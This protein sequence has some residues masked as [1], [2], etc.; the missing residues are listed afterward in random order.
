MHRFHFRA[1]PEPPSGRRYDPPMGRG[2]W[3]TWILVLCGLWLAACGD[4]DQGLPS[5]CTRGPDAV[6]RALQRAPAAVRIGGAP[7][8]RCVAE[9]SDAGELQA[10]GTSLVGAAAH[11]AAAARRDPGGAAELRLGYLIGAARRGAKPASGERT[12]LLR[13]LEQEAQG[14]RGNRAAFRRGLEAGR[15]GG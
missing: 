9:A 7:L 3:R 8:S 14:L 6:G 2:S 11:L 10:T 5:A 15:R 13:R 4:D 12:E 1:S